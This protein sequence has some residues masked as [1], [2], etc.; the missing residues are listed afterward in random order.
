MSLADLIKKRSEKIATATVAT[1]ATVAAD[2]RPSVAR[3]AT[4][5]VAKPEKRKA[6]AVEK[7]PESAP[8]SPSTAPITCEAPTASMTAEERAHIGAYLA[9]IGE[10][11]PAT[12]A[13]VLTRCELDAG[14]R[15]YFLG[16]ARQAPQ[17]RAEQMLSEGDRARTY[18]VL[19]PDADPVLIGVAVRGKGSCTLAVPLA[20]YDPFRLLALV[21][22]RNVKAIMEDVA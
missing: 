17:E 22:Q 18:C 7:V 20:N 10:A 19:H 12:I 6:E 3:V 15:S 1:V 2:T 21:G 13:E 16:R 9:H 8:D 14:A 4:V 5:A 11:D